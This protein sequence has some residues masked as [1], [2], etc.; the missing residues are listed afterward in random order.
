[1]PLSLIDPLTGNK[2]SKMAYAGALKSKSVTL[3]LPGLISYSLPAFLF[4]HI[5]YTTPK[6]N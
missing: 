6:T 1:M 2:L 5:S 4:F 3:T